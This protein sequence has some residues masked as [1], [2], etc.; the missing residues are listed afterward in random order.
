MLGWPRTLGR[1]LFSARLRVSRAPRQN[2]RLLMYDVVV[3]HDPAIHVDADHY[4]QG[5]YRAMAYPLTPPPHGE[6]TPEWTGYGPSPDAAL[7]C[8]EARLATLNKG[9]PFVHNIVVYGS[10]WPADAPQSA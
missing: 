6:R 3:K 10:P 8:V 5:V 7:A 4:L 9:V 2:A 1:L